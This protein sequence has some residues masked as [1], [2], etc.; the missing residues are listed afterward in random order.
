MSGD[1]L[2]AT[3]LSESSAPAAKVAAQYARL[4]GGRLHVFHV[5]PWPSAETLPELERL[6]R[7]LG[8]PAVIRVETGL[9]AADTIVDYAARNDIA[10]IVIGTHGR[11]GVSRVLL[12]SVA[13]RVV[14]TA[15]APVLTVPSAWREAPAREPAPA[16]EATL[17]RCLVCRE[18]TE[19]LICAACRARI[20]G[21]ALERKHRE[22]RAGRA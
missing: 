1:V 12:G 2:F 17:S 18:P 15:G 22:E 13:E 20:R 3:D 8:V 6:T 14:R 10:L 21:E 7:D 16:A 11:T 9:R 4:L 19:D 5:Q